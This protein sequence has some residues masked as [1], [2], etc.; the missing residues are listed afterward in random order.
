MNEDKMETLRR[1]VGTALV[2]AMAGCGGGGGGETPAPAPNPAPSPAPA[3]APAPGTAPTLGACTMFPATAVFNT[4]IDDVAR[5]PPHA[6]SAAWVATVGADRR[7]HTDW[8]SNDN[9]AL[10]STYYGIPINRVDGSA[11]TTEWPVLSYDFAPSGVSTT[12]GWPD[13]SDCAVSGAGGFTLTRN[14][15][16]VPAGQRR[17]PFPNASIVL[18]EGGQC[19][20]PNSCGD[21]HVLVVEQGACRLWESYFAYRLSGQWYA[22]S[23]AAWDLNSLALRPATWTSADA[24]GLPMTPLLARADEASSG[25]VRHALRVTFQDSVLANSF[26]WP[27]RHGAG[28]ATPG[29]VPFGA[30]LRL[31]AD[32]AIPDAWTTQAKALATAMKQYGLYVADIGSNFYVQGEPS[33]QWQAATITQ[34]QTIPMSQMEFVDLQAIT[35]DPRWSADSLAAGW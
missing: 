9:P 18:N 22:L 7:F 35:S 28:S 8:G 26:A 21:H 2:L 32:F 5:F 14:C 25:E 31:K 17:F 24:A 10:A 19:H 13:E 20:D 33:A 15:S 6:S 3:P 30:V 29:G 4:R 23:T 16:T 34:L 12:S 11:A 27:A 1:L